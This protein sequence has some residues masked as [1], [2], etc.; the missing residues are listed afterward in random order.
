[1]KILIFLGLTIIL[2]CSEKQP[3]PETQPVSGFGAYWYQGKAE[4]NRYQ[5]SQ[6]RYGE[7]REGDAILIFVTEDF[8][9]E[10]LVKSDDPSRL[11]KSKLPV[12]KM[13]ATRNFTTGIYPYSIMSSVFTPVYS[14][15]QAHTVKWVSSVQEWCGISHLQLE[16]REGAYK[17]MLNSYF[18]SEGKPV[19]DI[20]PVLT[21]DEL[22]NRIRI[23]PESIVT[24]EVQMLPSM[25]YQRFSHEDYKPLQAIISRATVPDKP[26]FLSSQADSLMVLMIQYPVIKRQVNI[27]YSTH[28]PHRIAGWSEEGRNKSGAPEMSTATLRNSIQSAYWQENKRTDS[29]ARNRFLN[30]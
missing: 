9:A 24:G 27:Y 16:L 5:L 30:P 15:Q 23:R 26:S 3:L 10:K 12:L 22:M 17:G 7:P 11:G 20:K 29:T 14:S 2:G 4:V 25:L 6:Q 28:F 18:E 8:D 13:N 1:M 21:E 19:Y